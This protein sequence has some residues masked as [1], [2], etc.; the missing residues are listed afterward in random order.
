MRHFTVRYII[1]SMAQDSTE[2]ILLKT[3]EKLFARKGY[4]AVGV[5]EIV[6]TAGVTKPTLYYYFGSKRGLLAEIVRTRGLRLTEEIARAAS[7]TGDFFASLSSTLK[8]FIAFAAAHPDFFRFHCAILN[9]PKESEP[10]LEYQ[11]IRRSLSETVLK[12]FTNATDIFG[13]MKGKEKLYSTLFLNN[14][15][16]IARS[17]AA[18]EETEIDNKTVYTI[19][20]SFIYGFAD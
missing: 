14:A 16:A 4:D 12:L 18:E 17:H 15:T 13:N 7:Y 10:F 5:Q 8:A 1:F 11:E 9:A 19:I 20:H 6:E 2:D 3:A